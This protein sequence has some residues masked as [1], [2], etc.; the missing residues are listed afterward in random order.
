MSRTFKDL[1]SERIQIY[2]DCICGTTCSISAFIGIF[3][4]TQQEGILYPASFAL[5]LLFWCLY[6][7]VALF[8]IGLGIYTYY[9][10][11]NYDPNAPPRK[12]LRAP[13]VG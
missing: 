2:F 6:L 1:K 5:G 13:M 9:K 10:A 3:V 12:D 11:K 4:F 7:A 8:V